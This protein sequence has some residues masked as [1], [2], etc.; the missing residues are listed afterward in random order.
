MAGERAR[1]TAGTGRGHQS[2]PESGVGWEDTPKAQ[3]QQGPRKLMAPSHGHPFPSVVGSKWQFKPL[4]RVPGLFTSLPGQLHGAGSSHAHKCLGNQP[5]PRQPTLAGSH[6]GSRPIRLRP[7]FGAQLAPQ[8]F[9]HPQGSRFAF[10][11]ACRAHSRWGTRQVTACRLLSRRIWEGR[12]QVPAGL[13]SQAGDR[14]C[15]LYQSWGR[16]GEGKTNSHTRAMQEAQACMGVGWHAELGGQQ[17][18]QYPA[19]AW[20]GPRPSW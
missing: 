7:L 2:P 5:A 3:G 1:Y 14:Q 11:K 6:L 16:G 20:L 17:H 8:A 15:S 18:E 12:A 13:L 10:A 19:E 9:T 4:P